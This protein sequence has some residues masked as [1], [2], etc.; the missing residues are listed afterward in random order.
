[1]PEHAHMHLIKFVYQL[2]KDFLLIFRSSVI[3]QSVIRFKTK[4]G[5]LLN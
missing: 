1:M 5:E 4:V 2:E 3:F